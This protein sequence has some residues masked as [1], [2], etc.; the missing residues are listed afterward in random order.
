VSNKSK[1]HMSRVAD[2][3]CVLCD[4]LGLGKSPAEVHHLFDRAAKSDFLTA[5]L[6][7]E[8]H[9][10]PNGFHG[11]GQR[12]FERRYKLTEADLL[13]MTLERLA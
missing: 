10:G 7:P 2:L 11:L 6:C 9:R 12:A 8:H 4:H 1:I 13:A 5:A 3:G